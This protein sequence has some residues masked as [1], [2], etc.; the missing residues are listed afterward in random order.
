MDGIFPS[1]GVD[2]GFDLIGRQSPAFGVLIFVQQLCDATSPVQGHPTH[3][4]G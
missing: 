1:V 4:F 2:V 3:D